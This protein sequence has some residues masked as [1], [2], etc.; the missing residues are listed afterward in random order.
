MRQPQA[1]V[2]LSRESSP[3]ITVR[4]S[5]WTDRE[6][7]VIEGQDLGPAVSSIWGDSD[8]EYW[9]MVD[10][11]HLEV[12]QAALDRKLGRAPPLPD[13]PGESDHLLL[14]SIKEAWN[15][16]LFKTDVDFRAW[17]E[18]VDIPNRFSSYV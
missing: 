4:L 13:G 6:G 14:S 17:L 16:G 15:I 5:A 9:L 2:K 7:L 3:N 8:Y 1:T 11:E 18:A 12:L 10:R